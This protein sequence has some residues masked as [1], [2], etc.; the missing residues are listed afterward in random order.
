MTTT[1][2]TRTTTTAPEAETTTDLS[3]AGRRGPPRAGAGGACN[4][5]DLFAEHGRMVLGLCRLLLRD[6]IEAEDAAQQAFVSAHQAVLRGSRPRDAPAWL[7]AIARNECRARIR[8]RMRESVALPELPSDLP[9]PVAAA[10]RAADLRSIWVALG[11]LPRRQRKAIVLR[12]FGGLSYHELGR[13]LGLSHSAVESLLFRARQRLRSLVAGA[14]VAA[15]PVALRDELTRMIPGFDPGS[16]S[17]VARVAA[18]PIAWKLAGAA[19]GVGVVATGAGGMHHHRALPQP[20][21]VESSP[22]QPRSPRASHARAE[23]PVAPVVA[24]SASAHRDRGRT[25]PAR[26][27]G[28]RERQREV[29]HERQEAVEER[30]SGSDGP[31]TARAPTTVVDEDRDEPER[32]FTSEVDHDDSGSGRSGSDSSDHGGGDADSDDSGADSGPD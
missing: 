6:P 24:I 29:E 22:A 2:G 13:V 32:D 8:V 31:G 7:A 17:V 9:D 3:R 1:T 16:A 14:N 21:H 28:H 15:V 19:V 10:I 18:V 23:A 4:I 30:D 5:G 25:G 12:E 20:R 11:A 27:D 26:E